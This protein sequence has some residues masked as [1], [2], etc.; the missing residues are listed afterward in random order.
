MPLYNVEVKISMTLV[1]QAEDENHA[2]E[3]AEDHWKDSLS[4]NT[5]EP[6]TQVTGEVTHTRNLRDGWCVDCVPYGGK[7]RIRDVLNQSPKGAA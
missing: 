5:P 6:R 3:V 2:R 7:S 1:V 4:D